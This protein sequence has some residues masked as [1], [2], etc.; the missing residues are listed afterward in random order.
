ME[1]ERREFPR[2]PIRV[3]VHYTQ[4]DES[5][6][7]ESELMG[8]ALDVSLGGLLLESKDF[9]SA[10]NVSVHFVDIENTVRTI[11]CRMIYS[12]RVRDGGVHTGLRFQGSNEAKVDFVSHIIRAYFYRRKRAA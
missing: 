4:L 7:I 2:I 3:A 12:R 9:I 6:G 1:S 8:L 11:G 10:E 5:G